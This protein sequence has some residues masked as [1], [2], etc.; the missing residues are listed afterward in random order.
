MEYYTGRFPPNEHA[1]ELRMAMTDTCTN[2]STE[3]HLTKFGANI[4]TRDNN[5]NNH[6][7]LLSVTNNAFVVNDVL[8]STPIGSILELAVDKLP[9]GYL[10]C[11]GKRYDTVLY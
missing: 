5:T 8:V 1:Y 2:K 4:I 9:Y 10:P 6:N 3:L 11:N 7:T